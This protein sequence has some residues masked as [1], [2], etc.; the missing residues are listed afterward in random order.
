[1]RTLQ[2]PKEPQLLEPKSRRVQHGNERGY[3]PIFSLPAASPTEGSVLQVSFTAASFGCLWGWIRS[4]IRRRL[5][6]CVI[7][8]GWGL[9]FVAIPALIPAVPQPSLALTTS[10]TFPCPSWHRASPR[11]AALLPPSMAEHPASSSSPPHLL[12]QPQQCL[13]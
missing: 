7:A 12:E 6:R 9:F 10:H 3:K 1:M 8:A 4:G 13:A 11:G 2:S 5:C